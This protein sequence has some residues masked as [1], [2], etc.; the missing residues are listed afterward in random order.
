M[1]IQIT[2]ITRKPD[3]GEL[4]PFMNLVWQR[5]KHAFRMDGPDKTLYVIVS[6]AFVPHAG[7]E[8][9]SGFYL[10]HGRDS[11]NDWTGTGSL[12][13]TIEQVAAR[14]FPNHPAG[15]VKQLE[16]AL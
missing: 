9:Y 16:M 6:G 11:Q 12:F 15:I 5:R 3:V 7:G 4:N 1:Q 10:R 8:W 2:A 14:Y 13:T